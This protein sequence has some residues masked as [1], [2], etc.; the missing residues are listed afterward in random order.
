L[1]TTALSLVRVGER[2]G[3]LPEMMRSVAQIYD[4]IVRNRIKAAL[5]IIEPTAIVLIGGAVGLVAVAIFMAITTINKV[6]GL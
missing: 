4:E 3:N 2:S 1:P 6:P 5:S